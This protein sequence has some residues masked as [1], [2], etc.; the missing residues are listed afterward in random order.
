MVSEADP[1]KGK[2]RRLSE[3][4]L[5]LVREWRNHPHVRRYMYT[6]HE[7]SPEEHSRWF[8]ENADDPNR[9]LLIFE[10]ENEPLGFVHFHQ[11]NLG[12]IADWGFYIAPD[13]PSGAGT[14]LGR[15][16]LEYAFGRNFHKVCGQVLA[17]N[18]KSVGFHLRLGFKQEGILRD[19]HFDGEIYHSIVCFG[20]LATEWR[21]K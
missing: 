14:K 11:L 10:I 8:A 4:D 16:A 1:S 19:Q 3:R 7:I 2:V 5:P 20:L 18:E 13:S 21:K 6:Q 12:G 15:A 9:H 17:F